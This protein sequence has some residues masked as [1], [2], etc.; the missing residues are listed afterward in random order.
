MVILNRSEMKGTF[1]LPVHTRTWLLD[2]DPSIRWQVLRDLADAD[3]D[4][5]ASERRR[6]ANEGWGARLL[7]LQDSN[8]RWGGEL[9]INKWLS[10]TY[11]MLLLR[12]MGLEPDNPQ[13]HRACRELLEGGFRENGGICYAKT[14]DRIDNAVTGMILGILAY[15]GY[16]DDRVH[17]IA[18]YLTSEQMSDGRWEPEIGN[19]SIRYVFDS[20]MLILE[21]LREYEKRYPDRAGNAIESQARGREFLLNRRLYK[22]MTNGEAI[23]ANMTLFSF[24]PR[25]HYDVLVALDYFQECRAH[26]DERLTDV[27]ELLRSKRNQDG[28]WNLQNRHA[29]KTFFEMEQPARP[30]R[31]NTLRAFR[32]LKWWN[33]LNN[34]F[35][36]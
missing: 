18:G 3:E 34:N 28:T 33:G 13:A 9:Y 27:I 35:P 24:P 11:T 26:Y 2:S 17:A 20:T 12:Q 25:W 8:D 31:W 1:H 15:F 16:P 36:A 5:I 32:V 7:S 19:T 4:T 6:V 23:H 22:D 10:T 14:V 30:S 21:G 29:G